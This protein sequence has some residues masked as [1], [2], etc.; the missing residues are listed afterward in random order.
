MQDGREARRKVAPE[1]AASLLRRRTGPAAFVCWGGTD[2]EER[3]FQGRI[4]DLAAVSLRDQGICQPVLGV[5]FGRSLIAL[6]CL[7]PVNGL[8][9][10]IAGAFRCL[11]RVI[12]G[13]D[14]RRFVETHLLCRGM[15]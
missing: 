7:G 14:R 3:A 9:G 1:A 12:D 6:R 11:R 13:I 8:L 15:G 2:E 4:A 10:L 5:L